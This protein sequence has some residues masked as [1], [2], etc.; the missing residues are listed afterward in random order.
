MAEVITVATH[1][2][3]AILNVM[4]AILLINAGF[5]LYGIYRL[6]KFFIG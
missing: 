1:D 4:N 5:I 2:Y 3:Q 6:Y